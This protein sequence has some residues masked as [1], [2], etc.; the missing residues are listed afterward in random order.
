M[1][2]SGIE[3]RLAMMFGGRLAEELIFGPENVTTGASNDIQQ[4][5]D[6]ARR[7]V[8]EWG[9]SEKL[10]RLRYTENEEQVF[11]GRSIA[12]TQNVSEETAKLIDLETRRIIEEAEA[13]GRQAL[14]S[15]M[16]AL[17]GIAEALLI[18]ETLSGDDVRAI[19][20]GE[21]LDRDGPKPDQRPKR[22]G[23]IRRGAADAAPSPAPL[24][25]AMQPQP[26]G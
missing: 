26:E 4:A 6:L 8:T 1:R 15:R 12:K 22:K 7:M 19:V 21:P 11:L 17:H 10:G 20:D 14:E 16:D 13:R 23:S 18:D 5:T 25:G 9:M 2:K 3:A 24:G